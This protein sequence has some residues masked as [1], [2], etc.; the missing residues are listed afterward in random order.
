[1]ENKE[2]QFV[3]FEQAQ[4]L[5]KAGFDRK[6]DKMF[7]RDGMGTAKPTVALALK[8]FRDEKKACMAIVNSDEEVVFYGV[9][10]NKKF[11]G[12]GF[13]TY[14]AAES[15]ILDEL[16]ELINPNNNQ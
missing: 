15:A 12:V 14:E 13:D 4:R 9:I 8:W 2:L 3:S 10:S 5:N 7:W 11:S 16:L 1:M 6:C